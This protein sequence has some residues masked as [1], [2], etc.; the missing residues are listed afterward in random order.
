MKRFSA[1]ASI[2]FVTAVCWTDSRLDKWEQTI[3]D[4]EQQ[5]LK[6]IPE[7]HDPKQSWDNLPVCVQKYLKRVSPKEYNFVRSISLKQE[8]EFLMKKENW[9][10]FEA[11]QVISANPPGFSWEAV[12]TAR[13]WA[14]GWAPKIRL[15]DTYL[16]GVGH[17][18]AALGA[19]FPLV[20]MNQEDNMMITMGQAIRWLAETVLVPSILLPEAG[21]VT[22]TAVEGSSN[23]AILSLEFSDGDLKFTGSAIRLVA[24]FDSEG[25]MT[26]L[27]GMRPFMKDD[28]SFVLKHWKVDFK[29]YEEQE[30]GSW[31]PM[32]M[33]S[34]WFDSEGNSEL[35]FKTT[36]V[37]LQY[38]LNS[39]TVASD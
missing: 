22:W 26:Q 29:D 7:D 8:G 32:H 1:L 13:T 21:I 34:G 33:E 37:A 9:V 27:L 12:V 10:P 30:E 28:N 11:R 18:E 25:W 16:N 20:S 39:E 5:L 36:N 23:K 31:V 2:A 3:K 4:Y 35:Y 24:T 19:I 17:F 15:S 14:P 6:T 38:Q